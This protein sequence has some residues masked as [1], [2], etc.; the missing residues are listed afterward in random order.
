MAT[1]SLRLIIG[2]GNPGK[3]YDAS[4]HNAGFRVIDHLAVEH[5]I[6]IVKRKFDSVFG[7][8]HVKDQAVILAKPMAFMNRSGS[9]VQNLAHYFRI[10]CKDLIVIHD[11]IDLAFGRLKIIEK[12]GH[13]GHNGVKSLLDA[14]GRND[15]TRLRFGVGRPGDKAGIVGHVLGTFDEK[16]AAVLPSLV[17]AACDAVATIL[18]QGVR[19]GMNRFNRKEPFSPINI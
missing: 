8:G 3:A 7:R 12:G 18:C 19:E 1:A 4:R 9:P 15:F 13:G 5:D 14:F 2:L 16:E 17:S 10:H 6:D 11:D